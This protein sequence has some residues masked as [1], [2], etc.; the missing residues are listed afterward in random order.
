MTRLSS[1]ILAAGVA[2]A[3]YFISHG[4]F[5]IRAS[6]RFVSVKGFAERLVDA[7]L[8]IWPLTFKETGD[9]LPAL[10]SRVEA[11]R[12]LI[13]SFLQTAGFSD[14]EISESPPQV[15]DFK[16]DYYGSQERPFRYMVQATTTLRTERVA[17]VKAAMEQSDQLVSKGIVLSAES[18]GRNTE[19]LFEGLNEIKPEMI[20]EAT[21]NARE[22]ADQFA[23]DSGS[24]V[25]A[26]RTARQGLFTIQDR[27]RNSPDRKKVRVVTTVEYFLED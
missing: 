27:D 8:A 2:L 22:A 1:L 16:A 11:N 5:E 13:R 7:D 17:S 18:Y 23:K 10:Q 6:Q 4:L 21:R 3:G 15:T 19:F 25:G 26:I 12:S 24:E 9:D 20:A 14:A